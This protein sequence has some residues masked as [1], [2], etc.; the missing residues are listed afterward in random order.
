[1]QNWMNYMNA[2]PAWAEFLGSLRNITAWQGS[3][4]VQNTKIYD[5]GMDVQPFLGK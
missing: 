4:L 5:R 2:Q 3:A 1:M